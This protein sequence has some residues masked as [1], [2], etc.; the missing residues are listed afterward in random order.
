VCLPPLLAVLRTRRRAASER[1]R[2]RE[3]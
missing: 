1:N 2:N 3:G